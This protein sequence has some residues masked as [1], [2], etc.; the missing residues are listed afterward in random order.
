MN[1]P[2]MIIRSAFSNSCKPQ[3][4][5]KTPIRIS[6]TTSVSLRQPLAYPP[7]LL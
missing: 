4:F 3:G 7:Y 2:R 5:D 6:Q 1:G